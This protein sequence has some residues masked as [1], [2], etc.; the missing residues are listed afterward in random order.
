M[1]KI[2]N[3]SN[4]ST[5]PFHKDCLACQKCISCPI[6]CQ[7]HIHGKRHDRDQ[8]RYNLRIQIIHG[9]MEDKNDAIEASTKNDVGSELHMQMEVLCQKKPIDMAGE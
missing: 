6:Q 5:V 1:C 8:K 3:K 7:A 2:G 9:E 4:W